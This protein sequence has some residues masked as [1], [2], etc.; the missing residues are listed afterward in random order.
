M[1]ETFIR[2]GYW[3]QMTARGKVVEAADLLLSIP[4]QKKLSFREVM[5]AAFP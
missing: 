3:E 2:V 4:R 1:L 5:K